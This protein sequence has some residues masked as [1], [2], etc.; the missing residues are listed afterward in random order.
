MRHFLFPWDPV[1]Y[2]LRSYQYG[3]LEPLRWLAPV[4]LRPLGRYAF[5][6][7]S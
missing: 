1:L 2:C 7:F 3:V 6:V 5:Q 4:E